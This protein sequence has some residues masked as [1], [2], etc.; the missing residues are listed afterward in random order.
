M[1]EQREELNIFLKE[2]EE[3]L[4]KHPVSSLD[5]CLTVQVFLEEKFRLHHFMEEIGSYLYSKFTVTYVFP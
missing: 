1:E 3:D 4:A 5:S 2:T